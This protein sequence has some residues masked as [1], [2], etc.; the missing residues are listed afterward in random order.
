LPFGYPLP[1]Q[2]SISPLDDVPVAHAK[3]PPSNESILLD[4]L[5]G[6]GYQFLGQ[7]LLKA[8]PSRVCYLGLGLLD[9]NSLR[10]EERMR[11]VC[12]FIGSFFFLSAA[13]LE[14]LNAFP[15]Q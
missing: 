12:F 5:D 9:R 2:S 11:I 15:T 3:L 4:S 10:E 1:I 8:F 14:S 13:A 7:A 6:I